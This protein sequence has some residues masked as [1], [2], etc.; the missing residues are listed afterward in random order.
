MFC[1]TNQKMNFHIIS[2]LLINQKQC[3]NLSGTPTI[4]KISTILQY[5]FTPEMTNPHVA[6]RT[7]KKA[8]VCHISKIGVFVLNHCRPAYVK[9]IL[10]KYGMIGGMQAQC[11]NIYLE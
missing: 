1:F 11:A 6:Y 2:K 9:I 5:L 10:F 3:Y 4:G 7:M 8:E